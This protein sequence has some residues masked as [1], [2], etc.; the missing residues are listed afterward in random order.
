MYN[1]LGYHDRQSG[2]GNRRRERDIQNQSDSHHQRQAADESKRLPGSDRCANNAA[3]E[4]E[5]PYD[6]DENPR[7]AIKRPE[8]RDSTASERYK[9]DFLKKELL[10]HRIGF[11]TFPYI[12]VVFIVS[13][14]FFLIKS[15]LSMSFFRI[16]QLS[17]ILPIGMCIQFFCH[18]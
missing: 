11:H 7:Q 9:K 4:S 2:G 13:S 3:V 18:F 15:S 12:F 1:R 8:S 17:S 14:L 16:D 10:M 5:I 6:V